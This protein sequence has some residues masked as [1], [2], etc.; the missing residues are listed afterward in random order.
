MRN[1][2]RNKQLLILERYLDETPEVDEYGHFTGV[3][4]PTYAEPII[5]GIH[6]YPSNGDIEHK[7]FGSEYNFDLIATS[8]SISLD[9]R[10]ILTYNSKKYVVSKINKSLNTFTYG[11][12]KSVNNG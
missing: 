2:E 8:N 12:E 4:I 6:V 11:L 9:S 1:L 3:D 10:D 7:I 5:I